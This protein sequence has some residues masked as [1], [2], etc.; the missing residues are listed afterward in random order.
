MERK[1]IMEMSAYKTKNLR[2]EKWTYLH[3]SYRLSGGLFKFV[4]LQ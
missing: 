1:N 3:H 2:M 4:N